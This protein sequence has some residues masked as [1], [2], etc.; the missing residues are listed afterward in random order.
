MLRKEY[1][2]CTRISRGGN[3]ELPA[4]LSWDSVRML[5]FDELQ[6]TILLRG[7]NEPRV[8]R[9]QTREEMHARLELW[10]KGK[11]YNQAEVADGISTENLDK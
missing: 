4:N 6:V 11:W 8:F 7:E 3:N 2:P 10:F 5:S 1:A 9:F